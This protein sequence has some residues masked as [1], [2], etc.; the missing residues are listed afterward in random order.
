MTRAQARVAARA[1]GE[2]G[3][4][5]WDMT[6]TEEES[7]AFKAWARQKAM[8]MLRGRLFWLWMRR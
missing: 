6:M 3:I 5:E 2:E 1:K 4:D 7:D 8:K